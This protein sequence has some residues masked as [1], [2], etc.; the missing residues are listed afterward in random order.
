MRASPA[1]THPHS[2]VPHPSAKQASA[3][4]WFPSFGC[5][6]NSEAGEALAGAVAGAQGNP[7]RQA[8]LFRA[9]LLQYCAGGFY[10]APGRAGRRRECR[11]A[12]RALLPG[13]PCRTVPLTCRLCLLPSSSDLQTRSAATE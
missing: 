13:V 6:N 10:S 8:L 11:A 2:S 9:F 1:P 5:T 12:L 4:S 3:K 7:R